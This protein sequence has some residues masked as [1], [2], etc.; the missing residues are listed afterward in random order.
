MFLFF[1]LFSGLCFSLS[2]NPWTLQS[3]LGTKS[4]YYFSSNDSVKAPN[5]LNFEEKTNLNIYFQDV[6]RFIFNMLED[7]DRDILREIML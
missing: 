7:M 6:G 4:A 3:H 1:L 5:G 2:Q